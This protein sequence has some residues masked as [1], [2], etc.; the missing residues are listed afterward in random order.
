MLKSFK[1]AKLILSIKRIFKIGVKKLKISQGLTKLQFDEFSKFL[2]EKEGHL[3]D[4]VAIQGSRT[5]GTAKASSDI[6]IALKVDESTFNKMIKNI[7]E[8]IMLEVQKKEQCNKLYKYG[9][10]GRRS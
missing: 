10:S 8:H 5:K 1:L 4:D 6:D 2:R 9:N 7:L 3:S